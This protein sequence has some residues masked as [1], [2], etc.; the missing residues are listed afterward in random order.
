MKIQNTIWVLEKLKFNHLFLILQELEQIIP[1]SS[2]VCVWGG[3]VQ[4]PDRVSQIKVS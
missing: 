1:L 3:G 2:G 4:T